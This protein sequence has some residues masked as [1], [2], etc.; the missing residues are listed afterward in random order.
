MGLSAKLERSQAGSRVMELFPFYLT[1]PYIG[2]SQ[3]LCQ[4]IPRYYSKEYFIFI[5]FYVCMYVC[6][7]LFCP[8]KATPA[9]YGGSQ[10]RGLIGAV[11]TGLHHSHSNSRSESSLRPTPQLMAIPL[12]HNG[13][14]QQGMFLDF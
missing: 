2:S 12:C 6:M 14:S 10:A 4:G 11:V 7:Y 3:T 9:A 5:L 8:F 13:N 1:S